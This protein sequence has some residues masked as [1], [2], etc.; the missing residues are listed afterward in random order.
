[1][2]PDCVCPDETV[3]KHVC[4]ALVCDVVVVRPCGDCGDDD[5]GACEEETGGEP[6]FFLGVASAGFVSDRATV[7]ARAIWG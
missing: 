3:I 5:D 4:H 6:S 2:F 7:A 1:M